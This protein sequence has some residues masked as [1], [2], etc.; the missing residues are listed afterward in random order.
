MNPQLSDL[1]IKM[2]LCLL[3][4]PAEKRFGT[5]MCEKFG[6]PKYEISRAMSALEKDGL[7][8][9]T[10]IRNP[11]LTPDGEK[12]ATRYSRKFDLAKRHFI[13]EGVDPAIAERDAIV[14]ALHCS[15]ETFNVIKAMEE[16]FLLKEHFSRIKIFTGEEFCEAVNDGRYL[17]PFIIY[18]EKVKKQNN[19]SM[20]N[21]G[22]VHPC[23]LAVY[24]GKGMI[25]LKACEMKER[26]RLNGLEMKGKINS[27]KY[28]DGTDFVEA[29]RGGQDFFLPVECL[30]FKTI[31][32]GQGVVLHGSLCL[33]MK[34]SVGEVHMPESTAIFTLLVT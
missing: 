12:L 8:D 6:L 14:L 24:D 1:K 7:V 29:Y 15:D 33:K 32:D 26:S 23:E 19:V 18:R 28:F 20:A 16:R 31:G 5:V 9:R 17:L 2:L 11:V 4:L 10:N 21:S 22:F 27:L 3:R 25:G 34:C 30:N 13:Y